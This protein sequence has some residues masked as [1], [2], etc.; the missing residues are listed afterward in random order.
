MSTRLDRL[1]SKVD[2]ISTQHDV[3]RKRGEAAQRMTAQMPKVTAPIAKPASDFDSISNR[4]ER[5]SVGASLMGQA[6]NGA[7]EPSRNGFGS[8]QPL[9][10]PK[11][12]PIQ[13]VM[14]TIGRGAGW[15]D[16]SVADTADFLTNILPRIEGSVMGVDPEATFTGQ[17]LKPATKATGAVSEYVD[18]GLENIEARI[19]NDTKDSELAQKATQLGSSTVAA[20]PQAIL[21][22]LSMGGSAATQLAPQATG[23]PGT[24][25]SA[26]GKM[27]SKPSFKLSFVQNLGSGYENAK[28]NGASDME[29]VSSAMLSSITNAAIESGGGIDELPNALRET[30]LDQ[31][32]RLF[33]W[34]KSTL[35]EVGE[36]LLQDTT[37]GV[38][39]K[40]IY[41][42]D[43]P[44]F[45]ASDESAIINPK[46]MAQSAVDEG[47]VAAILG[48]GQTLAQSAADTMS[49]RRTRTNTTTDSDAPQVQQ[50]TENAPVD[51]TK[52]NLP[53]ISM[54][55]FTNRQSEVFNNVAYED[56]QTQTSIM[57]NTH[58]A[59]VGEGRVVQIPESTQ[60]QTEAYYPDLRDM[61]KKDRT[62]IL[63]QKISE[64]KTDLRKFLSGLRG[65]NY[66][67]EINGNI[68]DAK[69]YD[70]GIKEV[71]EKV[72]QDKASMLLH[73][74]QIFRNAQY[75][76][77]TPDY[78]GDPNVY[79]WNY[80]YT[81]VQIGSETV[82]VRIAVRDMVRQTDAKM[83]SQIYNWGI[84]KDAVLGVGGRGE[85]PD[86]T[87]AS[88]SASNLDITQPEQ[89]V[90][91]EI[92]DMGA[93][94]SDF[95]HKVKESQSKTTPR[96][97]EQNNIPEEGRADNHYTERTWAEAR[98]NA[99][100]SLEQDYGFEVE[101]LKRKTVWS[102]EDVFKA[103]VILEDL[104]QEAEETHNWDDHRE[105]SKIFNQHKEELG[106]A[107]SALRGIHRTNGE[108]ILANA[109]ETLEDAKAGT[110]TNAV[111]NT[112]SEYSKRFDTASDTKNLDELVQIIRETSATRKTNTRKG[113]LSKEIDWAL[114][115]L[116]KYASA[117]MSNAKQTD[118]MTSDVGKYYDFLRNLA[119]N[120]IQ[121]IATDKKKTSVGQAYLTIRRNAMLSKAA[122]IMRNLVGNNVFDPLDSVA[123]N[124]SVPLDM[125]LSKFTG[126][127]SVAVDK[128]WISDA[129]RKGSMD[130]L[131][132]ALLEV[133]LDVNS[134]SAASKYEN[135]GTRTFH[136]ANGPISQLMSTW[137]KYMVYMLT[138]T[139]EFQKG[140]IAA[141]TQRGIDKLYEQGKIK[142]DTLRNAGEQE[143]LYRTFQDDNAVAGFIQKVRR[144]ANEHFRVGG[145]GAGDLLVPF[146]QVPSTLPVRAAEYSPIG[147]AR[148]IGRMAK[149]LLDAKSGKLTAAQQ[150]AA[151]KDFGRGFTGTAMIA[152]AAAMAAKG[153][154]HVVA[155]G[156]EEE[157][158]DKAA[159]EKAQG[160]NG[161]QWN[162][163]ATIRAI[164]GE[165]ADWQDGDTLMSIAFLDPMNAQL[166][167]GALIAEDF[168][169]D[170]ATF[171]RIL[172]DSFSGALQSFLDLPVTQTLR[173]FSDA[174]AYS[175]EETVGGKVKD[176]AAQWA[177][178]EATSVIPN[179]LKGIAQGTDEYQRDLYAKDS[180]VGQT[181]DNIVG[182][183][184]GFRQKFTTKKQDVYGNDMKNPKQPLNF[185]NSNILPGAITTYTE[186]D[187]Q[188]SLNALAEETG[189]N[190]M[191]LNKTPPKSIS[192]DGTKVELTDEQQRQFMTERSGLYESASAALEDNETYQDFSI[193]WKLDA[194]N[195]AKDYVTQKAKESLDAGFKP[196]GWISDLDGATPEE[197]SEALVLRVVEHM[198]GKED[199]NKS[200]GM[201]ILLENG[202][203]DDQLAL[204]CMT[205]T[206]F[207]AYTNNLAGTDVTVQQFLDVY[208]KA[209]KYGKTTDEKRQIAQ[210]MIKDMDIQDSALKG[211]FMQAISEAIPKTIRLD[212]E[213]PEQELLDIGDIGRIE[214]QMSKE[215][216]EKYD[217][218]VKDSSVDMQNYLDFREFLGS[219]EAKGKKDSEGNTIKGE[220]RMDHTIA[221]LEKSNYSD[222]EKGRLFCSEFARDNCPIKWRTGLPKMPKK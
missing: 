53:K 155:P 214:K 19:Q 13:T 69:L 171:G 38:I 120:G 109:S 118:S 149:V 40:G 35:E 90:N 158:K 191:Y 25:M 11:Q 71:M 138:A 5:Q 126:T 78:D 58:N 110:G 161:A 166:T 205:E 82:G 143:A 185:M 108:A 88:S 1:L 162:L 30:G 137:E 12:K 148:G 15:F 29:A 16:K 61:K 99:Q 74:D 100:Q 154:I 139:D 62:P 8:G 68:L 177:A 21:A 36:G 194:Y 163:D 157:N 160:M 104:R 17:I 175:D 64:L 98:H 24:A 132:M 9:E 176:A 18:E 218:F 51:G 115:R 206:C 65:V 195:Y 48:G 43:K 130:G 59:M 188:A 39:E 96:Y 6:T 14:D 220:S 81:P 140:G 20:L 92:G 178:G 83:D 150:A 106:R 56:T 121:A 212:A 67:F 94:T 146:A 159:S 179:A 202:T 207:N 141:E 164:N 189:V 107:F 151:V 42:H 156:G 219:E 186:T 221:W 144:A 152:A 57:Q 33:Q 190:S 63:K 213:V 127:R 210:D 112:V 87:G 116:Y 147:L 80:F 73:S 168:K 86:T 183:I 10:L 198:A 216:R 128:S 174:Y 180:L 169:N 170:K 196:D 217:V 201:S 153:I 181:V 72:T 60:A 167:T 76:Y 41:D 89:S 102:D 165:S 114:E 79:R 84:K 105:W 97:Y 124:M 133:G 192:V 66:E 215:Q 200:V 44:I 32:N 50:K 211:T 129:K 184:P 91:G 4:V 77:S 173:E 131:A 208:G 47:I 85:T 187:L 27:F 37:T 122:T 209:S 136:M 34:A 119:A 55:D 142:D 93:K 2:N 134:D 123:N 182:S 197:F 135:A 28:A 117:E 3:Q 125:L 95:P 31:P 145:V 23:I 203:I 75:L 52:A 54:E 172:E 199:K 26:A 113:G 45:S 222:E 204:A 103:E 70:T 193:D 49:K 46:R 22:V 101:D 111:M 7:S